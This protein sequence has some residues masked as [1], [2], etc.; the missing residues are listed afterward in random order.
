M[1][2]CGGGGGGREAREVERLSERAR[3]FFLQSERTN[4]YSTHSAGAGVSK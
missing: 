3:H 4:K 1:C 2:V